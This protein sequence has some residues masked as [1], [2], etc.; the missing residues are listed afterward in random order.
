[1]INYVLLLDQDELVVS[2][3]MKIIPPPVKLNVPHWSPVKESF[4]KVLY[5]KLPNKNAPKNQIFLQYQ[6]KHA[7]WWNKCYFIYIVGYN[8]A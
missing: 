3:K 8:F 5:P 2:I 1:M 4:I 6:N 7:G